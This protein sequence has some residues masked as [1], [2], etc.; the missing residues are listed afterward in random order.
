MLGPVLAADETAIAERIQ[1]GEEQRII[2]A[3]RIRLV[4]AIGTRDLDM[5]DERIERLEL[6]GDVAVDQLAMIHVELQLDVRPS[7]L[8]DI[9][10]GPLE[11]VEEIARHVLAVDRLEQQVDAVLAEPVGGIGD[12]GAIALLRRRIVGI[13]DAGHHVQPLHP[14]LV[15]IGQRLVDRCP[16]FLLAAD[17]RRH[18]ALAPGPIARRHVEQRLL[19]LAPRQRQ[20][21]LLR[22]MLVGEQELDGLET[23]LGC[24]LEAV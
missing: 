15:D 10:G 9:A 16:E 5:A 8:A 23:G 19:Q 22:R 3:G 6:A 7:G 14:G 1:L 18:P 20:P 21:D 11:I 17:Q 13:G 12:R 2:G 24:R 4:P